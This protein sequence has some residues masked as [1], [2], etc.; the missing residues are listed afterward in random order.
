MRVQ[1]HIGKIF[2]SLADKVLY[3]IYGIV[4]IY[5]FKYSD[6]KE[7]GI[8]ALLIG[9]HTWLFITGDS[10][11]LS[12][13]IQFGVKKENRPKINYYSIIML[14]IYLIPL[15][16]LVF[17]FRYQ[18]AS[19]FDLPRMT[20]IA[21]AL[22]ILTVLTIPRIFG[23]KFCFRDYK[24]KSLF[25]INLFFFGTMSLATFYYVYSVHFLS[26]KVLVI[27]YFL[28]TLASSITSI[29]VSWKDLQFSKYG[30]IKLKEILNFSLPLMLTNVFYAL[31][32]NLDS[33][34]IKFFF[35]VE[36]VGIYFSAKTL[37]RVFEETHNAAVGLF[38]PSAVKQLQNKNY[39]ELE[40]LVSKTISFMFFF[41]L[42]SVAI[43][44]LGAGKW[45]IST[46]LPARF[47][48]TIPLFNILIFSAIMLPFSLL[49]SLTTADNKP[50]IVLKSA[51]ISFLVFVG[52]LILVGIY[53]SYYYIPFAMVAYIYT[54]GALGIYY[55][56]K[57]YS[58]KFKSLFRAVEDSYH[59]L[60]HI[61]KKK[62]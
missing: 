40:D 19:L 13:I 22:P 25:F 1:E 43:L 39:K 15:P 55:G 16:L 56:R 58:Y 47:Y 36:S 4:Q 24:M 5:Q 57:L 32:R 45:F 10:I 62:Q 9:I 21:I 60:I 18:L 59:Y 37:Y 33:Y 27:I 20:D 54:Y 50:K 28:G 61:I 35:P 38:Y 17:L 26:F 42:I 8:F 11:A 23:A 29:I 51:I 14:L 6:P 7:F 46:F 52:V 49:L 53:G 44:E 2:W 48:D 41:F 30:E 31:P 12:S 34:I 3:I